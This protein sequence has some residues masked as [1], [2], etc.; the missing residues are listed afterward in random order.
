MSNPG[1]KV[2]FKFD[3]NELYRE[4]S[5][6][7]LKVGAIRCLMPIKIDGSADSGRK[8]VYVGHT[9]LMSPNG[10][11]PLQA[12]LEAASLEEAIDLFPAAMEKAFAE[13]VEQAKKMQE[14]HQRQQQQNE[15]RIITPG[16]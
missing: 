6:T 8:T 13:M 11:V 14:E 3:K 4:E 16:R 9:Q 10:M 7:D 5:L 2:E 15:S 1:E 12:P